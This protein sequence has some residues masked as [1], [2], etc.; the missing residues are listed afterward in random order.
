[1][2]VREAGNTFLYM[3]ENAFICPPCSVVPIHSEL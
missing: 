2:Y 3:S 1:M